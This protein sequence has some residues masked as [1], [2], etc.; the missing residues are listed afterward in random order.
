MAAHGGGSVAEN[1]KGNALREYG[2]F[3]AHFEAVCD[4]IANELVTVDESLK[5]ISEA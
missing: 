1:L 5:Q 4:R 2:S 3:A